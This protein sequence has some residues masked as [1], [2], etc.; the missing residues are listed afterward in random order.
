[1]TYTLTEG[2]QI[3]AGTPGALRSTLGRLSETWLEADEGPGT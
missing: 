1:M 2:R 3:L